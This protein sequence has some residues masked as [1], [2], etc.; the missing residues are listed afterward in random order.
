M[1]RFVSPPGHPY[2][3]ESS[4]PCYGTALCTSTKQDIAKDTD[5]ICITHDSCGMSKVIYWTKLDSVNKYSSMTSIYDFHL[6]LH[7]MS[8]T[9]AFPNLSRLDFPLSFHPSSM[10][11]GLM[12]NFVDSVLITL[13]CWG[14]FRSVSSLYLNSPPPLFGRSIIIKWLK[15][16]WNAG[17]CT[18]TVMDSLIIVTLSH[19]LCNHLLFHLVNHSFRQ[20]HVYDHC[21]TSLHSILSWIGLSVFFSFREILDRLSIVFSPSGKF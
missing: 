18:I 12:I 21:L 19:P 17:A 20:L 9:L 6:S 5:K 8:L 13:Q 10:C 4:P 7:D 11:T 3:C 1:N 2:L 16:L 15:L 14:I